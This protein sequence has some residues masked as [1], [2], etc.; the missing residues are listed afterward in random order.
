[1]NQTFKSRA[2]P[3]IEKIQYL[4]HMNDCRKRA[5][6]DMKRDKKQLRAIIE[7]IQSL[8]PVPQNLDEDIKTLESRTADLDYVLGKLECLGIAIDEL[9]KEVSVGK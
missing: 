4:I 1:M 9:Q 5:E 3:R 7:G 8:V 6:V 2:Y